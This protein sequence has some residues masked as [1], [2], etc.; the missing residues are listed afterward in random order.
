[1][2][3]FGVRMVEIGLCHIRHSISLTRV[4]VCTLV[5]VAH[6]LQINAQ[7]LYETIQHRPNF[8]FEPL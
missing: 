7:T 8:L 1:M 3:L 5:K 2:S 6:F 4:L